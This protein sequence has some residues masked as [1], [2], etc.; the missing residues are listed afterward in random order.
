MNR[1]ISV[2]FVAALSVASFT[3]DRPATGP[4]QPQRAQ[5]GFYQDLAWSPDGSRVSFSWNGEGNFEIYV[6]PADGSAV[7]NLTHDAASDRYATWSPDG[8][9]IAFASDRTAKDHIDIYVMGRDGSNPIRLTHEAGPNSF[10][11]WSK[12]GK[13]IAFMSK[14]DGHWQ[15]YVMNAD[16]SAQ[17][18]L[19][20]SEA[21]DE[22]PSFSPDSKHIVFESNR[23]GDGKDQLYV[24]KTDGSDLQRLTHNEANNVFPGFSADGKWILFG[25]AKPTVPGDENKIYKVKRD[26]T[27]QEQVRENGFFAR[28]SPLGDR[29]A[30]I[31]GRYPSSH[32]Y[33]MKVDGSEK[34]QIR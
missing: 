6:M 12:D 34:K 28:W 31:A 30:F 2:L 25:S 14:R 24:I 4:D 5:P 17:R 20:T 19:T 33:I 32:I 16:G 18:K 22:N 11:S 13:K 21:N 1:A 8:S 27:G 23:N 15:I 3:Q 29:I 7:T 26:G 10:P 9:K